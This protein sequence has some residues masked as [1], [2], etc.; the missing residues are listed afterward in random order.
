M[1]D[2][3]YTSKYFD[4]EEIDQ[5]LLQGYY[6]D[7][8]DKTGYSG[9]KDSFLI[10][11]FS[12]INLPKDKRFSYLPANIGLEHFPEWSSE[13]TYIRGKVVSHNSLLFRAN[14]THTSGASFDDD[15]SLWSTTTL[16]ELIEE[17]LTSTITLDEMIN[18][19][20]LADDGSSYLAGFLDKPSRYVVTAKTSDG[21]KVNVGI[22]EV[23][24]DVSSQVY[25]Q[26][27]TTHYILN[28]DGTFDDARQDVEKLFIY[29]RSFS[30]TE[31]NP[32]S[33][34]ELSATITGT[35]L[36]REVLLSE[37]EFES[38]ENIDENKI[39]YIYEQQ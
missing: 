22:L 6:D 27:F 26:K 28:V 38:L 19:N 10:D 31:G 23:L 13:N 1:E 25:T 20:P 36:S 7:F 15:A 34:R 24:S 4:C 14:S 18:F 21:R 11:L 5:R 2:P 9:D 37:E 8:V 35:L 39:Y 32:T 30:L 17:S 33:W 12:S 16:S 29:Y 3:K